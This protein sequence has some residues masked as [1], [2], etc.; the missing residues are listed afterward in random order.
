MIKAVLFDY[1]GVISAGGAG[2]ELTERLSYSLEINQEKAEEIFSA[3][4]GGFVT[5]KITVTEIWAYVEE[6]LGRPVKLE[7]RNIWNT[8]DEHMR[9][10]KEMLDFVRHLKSKGVVV[11]LLSNVIPITAEDIKVHGGYD[12]FDFTVLSCD[13]GYAKPDIEIYE[14]A[15]T[16]LPGINPAE[17]VFIDDQERCL[18]PARNLGMHTI[19]AKNPHQIKEDLN[20]LLP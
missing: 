1:G 9:P 4:W 19:L 12:S 17:I 7:D 2:N 20:K 14:L 13:V 18:V 5:G 3:V 16:K 10:L 11:G 6:Q 8:W 15:I